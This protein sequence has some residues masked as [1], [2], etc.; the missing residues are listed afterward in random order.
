MEELREEDGVKGEGSHGEAG[1][2]PAKVDWTRGQN[3][4]GTVDEESGCA[5]RGG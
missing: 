4:R 2:E 3:G 5:Q 1:E